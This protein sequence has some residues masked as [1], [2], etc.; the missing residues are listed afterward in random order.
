MRDNSTMEKTA[1]F[2]ERLDQKL[3]ETGKSDR[4]I[5]MLVTGKPDLI[6]DCRR[7]NSIPSSNNLHKL[8]QILHVSTDWLLGGDVVEIP[9]DATLREAPLDFKT[10]PPMADLPVLGTAHGGTVVILSGDRDTEVEQTMF[11][12]TQVIRYITRPRS[13][14]GAKDAYAIYVEGESMYPRFGPGEM[15][16][17]DP[18][19]P[20]RIGDDVIVQLS[21]N[22]NDEITAILIKR[23]V[24]RSASFLELEQFNPAT[25]F[26]VDSARVKRLHRICPAG[27]LLGG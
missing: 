27:D 12:P 14:T 9:S 18:R 11:E 17:V 26:R 13:L 21:E 7:K 4:A 15:A 6:R 20:P 19:V 25:R 2:F 10:Q 5:S 8:A 1:I 16:V 3:A 23:L 24:R 22:G